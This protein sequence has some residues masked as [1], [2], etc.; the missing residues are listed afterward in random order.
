MHPTD[1]DRALS[2]TADPQRRDLQLEAHPQSK[3]DVLSGEGFQIRLPPTIVGI[4][5]SPL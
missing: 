5:T 3:C 2:D 1:I 4:H